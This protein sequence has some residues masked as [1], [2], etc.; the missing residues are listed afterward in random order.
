MRSLTF[1]VPLPPSVNRLYTI[2]KNRLR[3]TQ[4]GDAFK[5]EAGWIARMAC[6]DAEFETVEAEHVGMTVHLYMKRGDGDNRLKALQDAFNGI[7]W[8]DDKQV[9]RGAWFV[10]HSKREYAEVTIEVLGS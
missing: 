7:V 3:L 1:T 5:Q 10:H 2:Q 6:R 4:L 8:R 9:K